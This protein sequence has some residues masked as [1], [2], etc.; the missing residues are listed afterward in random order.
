M[1]A[2]YRDFGDRTDRP[3][4]TAQVIVALEP[5]VSNPLGIAVAMAADAALLCVTLGEAPLASAKRTIEMI[6]RE[7]FIGVVVVPHCRAGS[8]P[9][10]TPPPKAPIAHTRHHPLL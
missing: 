1:P 5:V 8:V 10:S 6:G 2:H 4:A 7:R 9:N 3:A